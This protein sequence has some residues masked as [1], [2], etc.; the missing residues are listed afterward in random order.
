MHGE[1]PR[2]EHSKP[3][4]ETS[5]TTE[6]WTARAYGYFSLTMPRRREEAL[7]PVWQMSVVCTLEVIVD[8]CIYERLKV[9]TL[10][11]ALA[12]PIRVPAETLL[13]E[14]TV[15][16]SAGSPIRK[17]RIDCPG[18]CFAV[19]LVTDSCLATST[20]KGRL[21]LAESPLV[22]PWQSMQ[23]S[24]GWRKGSKTIGVHCD[25][26]T[27]TWVATSRCV[28]DTQEVASEFNAWPTG[29]LSGELAEKSNHRKSI[30]VEVEST[31]G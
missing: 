28:V 29:H 23:N 2:K 21:P 13:S 7:R 6:W 31:C 5:T 19:G 11:R 20:A 12:R 8:R 30:F 15:D 25:R 1:I 22:T 14:L 3:G 27:G 16:E 4:G 17:A 24:Q 18:P 26:S 9:G 10:C